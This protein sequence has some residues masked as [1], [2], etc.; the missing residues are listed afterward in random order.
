MV[1]KNYILIFIKYI[2]IFQTVASTLFL[3]LH[4][5]L[6]NLML[7]IFAGNYSVLACETNNEIT[8]YTLVQ[9][10][11]I[12]CPIFYAGSNKLKT[13]ILAE[14]RVWSEK[15]R[16]QYLWGITEGRQRST[17]SSPRSKADE[18]P[19]IM[20]ILHKA[21]IS[22]CGLCFNTNVFLNT[23]FW[24]QTNFLTKP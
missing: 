8:T 1:L 14:Y 16:T 22:E 13:L 10:N 24:N 3:F 18:S 17:V 4:L 11:G 20:S 2:E 12:Y 7:C 15:L 21:N 6:Y 9:A 19:N 23:E 5:L